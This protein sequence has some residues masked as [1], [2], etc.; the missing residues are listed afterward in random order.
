MMVLTMFIRLKFWI[1]CPNITFLL[2]FLV[3]INAEKNLP[4]VKRI[5]REGHEIGNHTFTHE[6]IAKVDPQRALL[7]LKLTR[8]LIECITGHSTILFRAP[9]NADSEPTTP[10][11]IIPVALARQQ[12]Y[13]DI[14]K[15][16][17]RKIGSPV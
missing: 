9:Y 10:E 1:Y 13:L 17:I 4:L 3:G 11:E 14:G 12:N 7:E 2:L 5:Y 8:L 15:I 6:N 16:L